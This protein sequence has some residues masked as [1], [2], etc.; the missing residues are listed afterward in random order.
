MKNIKHYI[1]LIPAAYTPCDRKGD[2]STAAIP[3]MAALY[4]GWGAPAVFICGSTG[5]SH[6][7]TTVE[8]RK[9]AEAWAGLDHRPFDLI[10]HVGSNSQRDAMELAA[11][12]QE[13]GAQAV[14]ALAPCYFRPAKIEDLVSFLEPIAA[15]APSLPFYFYDIPAL[16]GVG[17]PPERLLR[18]ASQRIENFAGIKFTSPD[19]MRLQSCLDREGGRFDVLFG[20]D[21]MLLAAMALGVQG[22]VGST[23]NYAAPIYLDVIRAYRAGDAEAARRAQLRS[24]KLVEVLIEHGVLRSGKAIMSLLGIDCGPVR[25]PLKPVDSQ[26][27]AVIEAKLRPLGIFD[28]VPQGAAR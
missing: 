22:A 11:H 16:T 12:A 21:E 23:Y 2:L 9:T 6:S 4:A 25:P 13:V 18:L 19:L 14:S 7:F 5:E 17:F 8:R 15:A 24:V 27:L 1:G 20:C 10:V 3:A 28:A 26:E